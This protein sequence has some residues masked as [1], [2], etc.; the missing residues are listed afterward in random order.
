[1]TL[2]ATRNRWDVISGLGLMALLGIAVALIAHA[3]SA[4]PPRSEFARNATAI[5]FT[6]GA[7]V[8]MLGFTLALMLWHEWTLRRAT[9]A[10][11]TIMPLAESQPDPALALHPGEKLTLWREMRPAPYRRRLAG[12]VAW[13]A[14]GLVSG[15]A[16]SALFDWLVYHRPAPWPS[17]TDALSLLTWALIWTPAALMVISAE[18]IVTFA[19][20]VRR[21]DVTVDDTGV[22][23]T[24]SWGRARFLPWDDI[25]LVAR[26][27][28]ESAH[29]N[30]YWLRGR[31]RGVALTLGAM[32]ANPRPT[33]RLRE[34]DF[35]FGASGGDGRE[36]HPDA[37]Q[38]LLAT[39]TVRAHVPIRIW[40]VLYFLS[41]PKG[42]RQSKR[43]TLQEASLCRSRTP[44]CGH[45]PRTWNARERSRA[46]G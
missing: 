29:G 13:S 24:P 1:M 34:S 21:Q 31:R 27:G 32:S 17:Q 41:P 16:M 25:K 45:R 14:A 38:R 40:E 3:A 37:I 10:G 18:Q 35:T 23:V 39:V 8:V 9:C 12:A 15:L 2:D 30:T 5:E 36:T 26:Q 43:P 4:A 7:L 46:S 33:D 11:A 28:A 22:T 6:L 44:P 19:M 42:A 20:A